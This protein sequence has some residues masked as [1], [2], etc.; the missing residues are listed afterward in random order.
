M[1][2]DKS[3]LFSHSAPGSVRLGA[4]RRF[5]QHSLTHTETLAYNQLECS[6]KGN[7]GEE[8][9]PQEISINIPGNRHAH[10]GRR[11]KTFLL[12]RPP[13]IRLPSLFTSYGATRCLFYA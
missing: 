6:N 13:G 11:R 1:K 10:S 12:L 4:T 7:G 9:K 8:K 2:E 3:L 5:H